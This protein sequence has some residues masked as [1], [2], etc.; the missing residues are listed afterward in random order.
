MT[1]LKTALLSN[2]NMNYVIRMLQKHIRVY[3]AEGYG[4]ELGVMMN[5][6]SSYHAFAPDITFLVEDLMEL[7]AHDLDPATAGQRDRKSVV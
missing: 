5:P 3:D 6:A 1:E 7:L 2:V 4:N